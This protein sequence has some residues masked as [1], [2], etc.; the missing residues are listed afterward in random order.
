VPK[1][2]VAF[3]S[4]G[5]AKNLVNTEQMMALAVDGGYEVTGD[6]E[7]A[8]VAVVNTCGFIDSA[9]SEAIDVILELAKQK[10]TGNL[11]GILV[12]GCMAQRHGAEVQTLLPEV[13]GLLGCGSYEEI[14][15]AIQGV[16]N[17]EKPQ[18]FGDID[19]PLQETRRILTTPSWTAYLRIAEGCDNRCAYCVIPSLRGKYRSRS[20]DAIL[21]EARWLADMGVKELL[22]IA[23][24]ITRYG[25]DLNGKRQLAKLLRALCRIEGFHWIRLHYLYPDEIDDDL[26]DVIATEKK[27]VKYLDIPLQHIDDGVLKAM[28]RRGTGRE[29]RALLHTLR[30]RIPGLV[31]R[32]SLICGLP[33]EGESEF[34]SLC[35]FLEEEQ[36]E[37]AGVF[38]F[39]P[40]E[41][42]EAAR[43]ENIPD[44]ETVLA[45]MDRLL[46][47]QTQCLDAYNASQLGR[48]VEVL[49]EGR[50][51][52]GRMHGRTPADSTEIDGQLVL[53]TEGEHPLEPGQFIF[54]TVTGSEDGD[55][56]GV[57]VDAEG[58][59]RMV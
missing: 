39:S 32:T 47:I 51:E 29:I 14:T 57:P 4:L 10:E 1:E 23:Q 43:M 13:D 45:R 54:V 15:K 53:E 27:I 18:L 56:L 20:M 52:A 8:Q 44:E 55:L 40:Q 22:V 34:E 16:L 12:A 9:K 46:A 42:T 19:A 31:L 24:D 38:A 36:I 7:T 3:V 48:Q 30:A 5:C 21:Q 17:G 41:G 59:A 49:L 35:R 6:P 33:G 37:R 50:D 58:E 28:N 2:R 25:T 26:I 11:R